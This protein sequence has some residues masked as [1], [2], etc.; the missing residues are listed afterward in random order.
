MLMNMRIRVVRQSLRL[1]QSALAEIL[2]VSRSAVSNWEGAV[3]VPTASNL[4]MLAELANVSFEWLA[5]NRGSMQLAPNAQSIPAVDALLVYEPDE[6]QLI[7]AYR[8]ANG[9][10][11]LRLLQLAETHAPK[12]YSTRPIHKKMA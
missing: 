6:L 1:S 10:Q 5:L 9:R 4:L 12:S 11:K 8:N 3:A 2:H 7:D